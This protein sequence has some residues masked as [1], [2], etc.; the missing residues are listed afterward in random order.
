ME[1]FQLLS[2]G[3]VKF[4]RK[5]FEG[6]VKLF[7]PTKNADKGKQPEA[8]TNELPPELDF[9]RYAKT[10]V[11]AKRKAEDKTKEEKK[12]E[13]AHG[14]DDKSDAES[15]RGKRRKIEDED[16]PEVPKASKQRVT[17]KGKD[18]PAAVETF[19]EL[20]DRYEC[21]QLLLANLEKN[22][23]KTPTGIQAYGV[24]ILMEKRDV[25][26]ISP[27][28][29]GK[30]L[31]YLIPMISLLGTPISQSSSED[32][33]K[34]VRGLV[35]APT[36]E[37]AGQIYNEC[38]KLCQGRKWRIVLYSKATAATLSNKEVRDK[39]DII[40]STPMR[41]VA[42]LKESKIELANVRHLILDEADR[43]LDAEFFPQIEEVVESCT[44]PSLQKAIFSAT[45]PA[46]AEQVA[47]KMLKN[48][49]RVVVG[50]K[51]TPL[52]LIR[53]SLVYVADESS[54]LPS[55][56]SYLT[57]TSSLPTA[58]TAP[59]RWAPPILIFTSTQPRAT[60]LTTQL[61]LHNIPNVD[62]LHASLTNK[63]RED[64]VHRMRM[65]ECWVL[66]CTEVVARGMDFKGVKGVINYDWPMTVQSYVHRIG[67]TGRA[68]NEGFAVTYWTDEDAPYLKTIAN[69]LLQSG[70]PVPDWILK[71][72]KPSA[73]RKRQMGKVKRGDD[74]DPSASIGRKD[75][76]KKRDMVLGSKRRKEKE[77]SG[78]G[79]WKKPSTEGGEGGQG[80][81]EWSGFGEV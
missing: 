45:L 47:M 59:P 24:P 28:G 34:G 50:L 41:L 42:S 51:D 71:L 72:P 21:P 19:H 80:K 26:A 31:A 79:K 20:R 73:I 14:N 54:K 11:P 2:K 16:T 70:S 12:K 81:A 49:I 17:A 18:V 43:M 13:K 1:A 58:A 9:F 29:T 57:D 22:G 74:V 48:P 8:P 56:V 55:L 39:T 30:T 7:Q 35:L 10:N 32:K 36:R 46:G 75:A 60:S 78:K 68:G 25:A 23:W 15:S 69:V 44:H 52:P 76:I 62:V 3:G 40:I 33:G 6:D 53:Q 38:L 67:R 65:G 37:L 77:E 5:R 63:Q 64:V 27:T 4:N 61:I 66:V